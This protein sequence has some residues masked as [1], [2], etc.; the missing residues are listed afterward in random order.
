[1]ENHLYGSHKEELSRLLPLKGK[2][3][4]MEYRIQL[5]MEFIKQRMELEETRKRSL[6]N[7]D[8]IWLR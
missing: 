3:Y 5:V 8:S 2:G 6:H 1:M 4:N 7:V